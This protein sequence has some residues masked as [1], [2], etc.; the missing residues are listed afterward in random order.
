MQTIFIFGYLDVHLDDDLSDLIALLNNHEG[1]NGDA[2][3]NLLPDVLSQALQSAEHA[4]YNHVSVM[5]LNHDGS[6]AFTEHWDN[7]YVA[8]GEGLK[9]NQ[10]RVDAETVYERMHRLAAFDDA[11]A[12]A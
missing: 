3:G 11:L 7:C 9:T 12:F 4:R 8:P 6:P 5:H 2:E 10:V 1:Q